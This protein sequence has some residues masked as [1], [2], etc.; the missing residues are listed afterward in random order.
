VRERFEVVNGL[1]NSLRLTTQTGGRKYCSQ[2]V[3]LVVATS[4][5]PVTQIIATRLTWRYA[6]NYPTRFQ[7]GVS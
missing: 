7:M 5:L 6:A 1:L 2:K 4:E 3:F